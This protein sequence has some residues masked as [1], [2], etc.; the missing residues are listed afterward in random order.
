MHSSCAACHDTDDGEK[1]PM[2]NTLKEVIAKE[3]EEAKQK[4]EKDDPAADSNTGGSNDNNDRGDNNDI[5]P[6]AGDSDVNE[7]EP[8]ST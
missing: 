6:D 3:E 2:G 1:H 4:D 5:V 7:Q 8:L